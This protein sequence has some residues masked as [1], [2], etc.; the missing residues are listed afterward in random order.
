MNNGAK[1]IEG[2]AALLLRYEKMETFLEE[3][4]GCGDAYFPKQN[5]IMTFLEKRDARG[6]TKWNELREIINPDF[7]DS[8]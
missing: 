6:F 1:T 8:E 5:E 4:W 2:L 3:L 7:D